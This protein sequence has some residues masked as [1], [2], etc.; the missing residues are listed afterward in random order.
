MN[1]ATSCGHHQ[2][3]RSVRAQ[4]HGASDKKDRKLSTC[5][6]DVK[7]GEVQPD[8]DT[9]RKTMSNIMLLIGDVLI[10]T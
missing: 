8:M 5:S 6:Y 1:A 4:S 7:K 9:K 10:A 3:T 2:C